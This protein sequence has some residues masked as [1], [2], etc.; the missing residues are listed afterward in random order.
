MNA[1][2]GSSFGWQGYWGALSRDGAP[3]DKALCLLVQ[4]ALLLLIGLSSD[5]QFRGAYG[6]ADAVTSVLAW[7]PA[8]LRGLLVGAALSAGYLCLAD[9]A[10]ILR[11]LNVP[12]RS[13]WMAPHFVLGL[14]LL[15]GAV[16]APRLV[17][18]DT[19]R[20]SLASAFYL[21]APAM[22]AAYLL[23]GY[24]IA[25]PERFVATLPLRWNVTVLTIVTLAAIMG[26]RYYEGLDYP[27]STGLTQISI[28]MASAFS[29][30]VG[31]TIQ[32]IGYNTVG[33]P[34]YRTG[35]FDVV[36]A[37]SCAGSEGLALI[38]GL[39]LLLVF[40]E[41]RSLRL[42]LALAL[43]A[44]AAATM[45]IVNAARIAALLYIGDHWSAEVAVNGFHANFGLVALIVISIGFA[46]AIRK[47]AARPRAVPKTDETH[48]APTTASDPHDT[49]LA[50]PLVVMIASTLVTGLTAGTFNW[51][52][53]ITTLV[54]A[55]TL[56][57]L[58]LP[59]RLG[60]WE[61]TLRPLAVGLA[62]LVMWIIL[63]PEDPD[64]STLFAHSL[65]AAPV[66]LSTAW[67]AVRVIGSA[68]VVPITEELAFRGFILPWLIDVFAQR[69]PRRMASVMAVLGSSLAF[70]M[71]HSHVL[72]GFLAGVAYALV[73]LH[74]RSRFDAIVAH[75][76]TNLAL[77][78]YAMALGDWSYL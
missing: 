50:I 56:W 17:E 72:P 38:S 55:A 66:L 73:Y 54:V 59:G 3:R 60:D 9:Q 63:I 36:I 65:F 6:A 31:H 16:I 15:A 52:Y 58:R 64:A 43:V 4:A 25:V 13:R 21:A 47:F 71:A 29:T 32:P 61:L 49:R 67:L 40:L 44:T 5:A 2:P 26:W 1:T 53:P 24:A 34:I 46:L 10:A 62:V 20:L 45:F 70:G 33:W 22:W 35:Q 14:V 30:L 11:L 18:V 68:L 76:T 39:L 57:R 78:L 51:L 75:G 77:C 48:A 28:A 69:V 27:G 41:R 23:T 7:Q 74:R 12:P 37:P 8:I 19:T 42:P